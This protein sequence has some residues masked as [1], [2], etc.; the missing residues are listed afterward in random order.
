MPAKWS[1]GR[2]K[3]A[4]GKRAHMTPARRPYKQR[5]AGKACRPQGAAS[6]KTERAAGPRGHEA[7]WQRAR[8]AAGAAGATGPGS[9]LLPGG[10]FHRRAPAQVGLASRPGLVQP[11]HRR[12]VGRVAHQ[13]RIFLD[14]PHDPEHDVDELV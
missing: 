5:L 4:I 11:A 2:T 7:V 12:V 8:E 13:I 14:L 1:G 10:A 3:R 9:A 6:A